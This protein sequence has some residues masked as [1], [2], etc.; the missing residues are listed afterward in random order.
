V[1]RW[2]DGDKVINYKLDGE[3]FQSTNVLLFSNLTV[4]IRELSRALD[5]FPFTPTGALGSSFF[6]L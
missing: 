5:P 3:L 6:R 1:W 4:S 2:G